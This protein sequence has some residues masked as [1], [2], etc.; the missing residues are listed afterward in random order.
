MSTWF[1]VF[2]FLP[3]FMLYYAAH[4]INEVLSVETTAAVIGL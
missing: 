3:E 1:H 2:G 4:K